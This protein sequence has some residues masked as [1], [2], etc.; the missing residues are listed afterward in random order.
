MDI[1]IKAACGCNIGKIRK[2]N[3]DNFY[4][5]GRM[6]PMH[7]NGLHTVYS[8]KFNLDEV[9]MFAVFD[10]MGGEELGE[11]ASFIAA[12]TSHKHAQYLKKYLVSPRE[13]LIKMCTDMNLAVDTFHGDNKYGLGDDAFIRGDV[14]GDGIINVIDAQ[15]MLIYRINK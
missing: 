13:F 15:L 12:E 6:L 2:N 3:E 1:Y 10:G 14:N 5:G 7:N 9:P 4:F 8:Q 11:V